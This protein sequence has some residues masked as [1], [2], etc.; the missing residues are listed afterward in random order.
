MSH[1]FD[2]LAKAITGN[3]RGITA[4]I[5]EAHRNSSTPSHAI[6][7]F[8]FAGG[9]TPRGGCYRATGRQQRR[10]K[11]PSIAC[12]GGRFSGWSQLNRVDSR[13]RHVLRCISLSALAVIYFPPQTN[14][15]VPPGNSLPVADKVAV[16]PFRTCVPAGIGGFC[17]YGPAGIGGFFL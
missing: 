17:S 5:R 11:R 15:N 1:D 14:S 8:C 6:F 3:V 16:D 12:L 7:H 2:H 10:G 4:I 9:T 13:N